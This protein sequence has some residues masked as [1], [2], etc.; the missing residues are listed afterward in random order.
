MADKTSIK[1]PPPF[2]TDEATKDSSL[3]PILGME[4]EPESSGPNLVLKIG[5]MNDDFRFLL[6][7]PAAAQLSRLLDEAVQR[8]SDFTVSSRI[9]R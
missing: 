8:Y 7:P 2:V 4:V 9:A 5:G 3:V 1:V 6:S